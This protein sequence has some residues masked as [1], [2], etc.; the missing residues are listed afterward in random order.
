M[1]LTLVTVTV[2]PNVSSVIAAESCGTSVSTVGWMNR[3]PTASGPPTDRR[4]AAGD[5]VV[6]VPADDV[7]L[8]RQRHRPD[9]G[10]RRR[11]PACT[12]RA[13]RVSWSRNASYTLSWT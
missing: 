5:R 11:C 7:D 4:A 6:D 3:S 2:G 9:L 8:G 10:V 1:S 13:R 12:S